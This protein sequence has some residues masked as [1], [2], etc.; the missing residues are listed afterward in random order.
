MTRRGGR[1]NIAFSIVSRMGRLV[2]RA[3]THTH[4][5]RRVD[6][7]ETFSSRSQGRNRRV[8]QLHFSCPFTI[9]VCPYRKLGQTHANCP[10]ERSVSSFLDGWKKSGLFTTCGH[11]CPRPIFFFLGG[12]GVKEAKQRIIIP[13]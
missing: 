7:T 10:D 12:G 5:L 8:Q 4:N 13:A 6:P 2:M 11:H 9:S 1:S 3:R